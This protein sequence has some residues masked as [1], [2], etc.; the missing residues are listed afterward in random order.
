MNNQLRNDHYV[1]FM[2]DNKGVVRF[3]GSGRDKRFKRTQGRNEKYLEILNNGATFE[4]PHE[5]ISKLDATKFVSDYLNNPKE[6]WNLINTLKINKSKIAIDISYEEISKYVYFDKTSPTYLRWVADNVHIGF[7]KHATRVKQGNPAGWPATDK[8]YGAIQFNGKT[9]P[10][11]RVIWSLLNKIDVPWNLI[12]NH[13][14]S[15][16]KNNDISNLEIVTYSVNS[17]KK[18]KQHNNST[19]VVGVS[20]CNVNGYYIAHIY[21]DGKRKDKYFNS[22]KFGHDLALKLA[23]EWR[24]EME[25]L[26]YVDKYVTHDTE[27]YLIE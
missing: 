10:I 22:N 11:H 1:Y 9:F 16:P 5:N 27:R 12:I 7:S 2:L 14:D 25:L 18:K 3:I 17:K 19:G 20:Y 4:F 24:N 26:H 15:D 8:N 13:I 21:I 6:C 23:S